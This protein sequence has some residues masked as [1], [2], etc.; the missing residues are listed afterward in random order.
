MV[1]GLFAGIL[2]TGC[3]LPQV[4][5]SLRSRKVEHFSWIYLIALSAGIGLWFAYGILKNDMEIWLANGLS[6]IAAL[7]LLGLKLHVTYE[8]LRAKRDLARELGD[9]VE[10]RVG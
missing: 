3:W 10:V 8:E 5:K 4:V 7:I 2:T 1:V 9:P 6:V